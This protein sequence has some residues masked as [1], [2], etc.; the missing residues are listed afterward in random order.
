M[1]PGLAPGGK[2]RRLMRKDTVGAG[3]ESTVEWTAL[4]GGPRL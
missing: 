4:E 2:E 1:N 3:G